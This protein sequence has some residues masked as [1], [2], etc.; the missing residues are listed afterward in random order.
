MP[1]PFIRGKNARKKLFVGPDGALE[2]AIKS[3]DLTREGTEHTDDV[4]GEQESRLDFSFSHYGGSIEAYTEDLN[5]VRRLLAL[6]SNEDAQVG[7]W[8]NATSFTFYSRDGSRVVLTG[9]GL[10]IDKWKLASAGRTD[11]LMITVPFRCTKL[12]ELPI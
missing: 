1:K 2:M 6:Q 10:V 9:T 5:A 8:I 4:N 12:Q 7:A 11:P 3:W